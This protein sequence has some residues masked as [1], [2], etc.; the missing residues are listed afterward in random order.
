MPQPEVPA[1]GFLVSLVPVPGLQRRTGGKGSAVLVAAQGASPSTSAD[2]PLSY[3]T[4]VDL[5]WK[6]VEGMEG[7]TLHKGKA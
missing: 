1:Q 4:P 2:R 7:A 3:P 6:N 5:L